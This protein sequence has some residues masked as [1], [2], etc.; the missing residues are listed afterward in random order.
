MYGA[1]GA[2]RDGVGNGD[3][4]LEVASDPM[5]EQDALSLEDD[6]DE[7]MNDH[8]PEDVLEEGLLKLLSAE[9]DFHCHAIAARLSECLPFLADARK[10]M[11]GRTLGGALEHLENII[12]GEE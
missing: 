1:G 9:K 7:D 5:E 12:R 3:P 8:V 4:V 6:E 10:A 11:H 2:D